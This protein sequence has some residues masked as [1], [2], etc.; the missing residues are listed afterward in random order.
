MTR[1]HRPRYTVG[2]AVADYLEHYRAEGR[3]LADT[4]SAF[5]AHVLPAFADT[6]VAELDA[7]ALTRWR[8]G[9]AET[10]A[11][12][13]AGA[14][15]A[16]RPAANGR[17]RSRATA[18]RLLT[19][20]KAALNHAYNEGLVRCEPV[21][22]RVRPFR[23]AGRVRVRWLEPAQVRRLIDAAEPAFASLIHAAV[24]TGCRYGELAAI[25]VSDV[26]GSPPASVHVH[27]A[28]GGKGL[29]SRHVP[30][31][32]EGAALFVRLCHGRPPDARV[33]LRPD[34]R[35]WGDGHQHRRMRAASAAAGIDPPANF[36]ALRH[37]YG[38]WL[39]QAG[40]PIH[41]IRAA[42]GHS[43]VELT[44]R[45]YAHLSPDHVARQVRANLPAVRME[46]PP[47]R[48]DAAPGG[49]SRDVAKAPD[50]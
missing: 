5:R 21:W 29:R 16:A 23:D 39:A 10:P 47:D 4:E 42:M 22:R 28:K 9:L 32:D 34:G 6:P 14:G 45:H 24:L 26:H 27:H 41:V 7:R 20:L 18:N 12:R 49:S 38:A 46:Q 2:Q 35:P 33:F 31:T 25:R 15:A 13:R 19:Y 17:H 48:C 1:N 50:E 37:C 11:L 44:A 43:S 3:A 40:V 36:H 8:N 30:L